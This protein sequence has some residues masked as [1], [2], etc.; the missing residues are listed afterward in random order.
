MKLIPN[1]TFYIQVSRKFNVLSLYEKYYAPRYLRIM[2]LT[3]SKGKPAPLE[4]IVAA[5]DS[6]WGGSLP[7][8]DRLSTVGGEFIYKYWE[9][10]LAKL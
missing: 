4:V 8:E 1:T 10:R 3:G 9:E 5:I 7:K 6:R 2:S